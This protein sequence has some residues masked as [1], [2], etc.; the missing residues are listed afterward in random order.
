[1]LMSPTFV[2]VTQ[3]GSVAGG[4]LVLPLEV[5]FVSDDNSEQFTNVSIV[6]E[7]DGV[8]SPLSAS[9]V[10]DPSLDPTFGSCSSVS[11]V[12]PVPSLDCQLLPSCL[13]GFHQMFHVFALSVHMFR[14]H[15]W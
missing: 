6:V 3:I 4:V 14:S 5:Q 8:R 9:V 10:A 2:A 12:V 11:W 15:P 7:V 13:T 1:M